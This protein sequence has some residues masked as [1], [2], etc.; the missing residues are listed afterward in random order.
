MKLIIDIS[1]ETCK[2]IRL[3]G[4]S[5]PPAYSLD[6]AKALKKAKEVKID[7]C[8]LYEFEFQYGKDAREILET[9]LSEGRMELW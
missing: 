1:E 5:L 7:D 3:H 4:L 8:D 2:E 6:L 9:V